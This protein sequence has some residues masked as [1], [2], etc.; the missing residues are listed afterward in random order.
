[1]NKPFS[2]AC[3]RCKSTFRLHGADTQEEL[4]KTYAT[5]DCQDCGLLILIDHGKVLDF[6]Q[7]MH[8]EYSNWPADGKNT[9]SVHL[10][11]GV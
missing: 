11:S 3:P 2:V 9:G 6:H 1:M 8:K 7:A 10:K 4:N 5:T